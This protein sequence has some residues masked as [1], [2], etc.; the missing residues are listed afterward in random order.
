MALWPSFDACATVFLLSLSTLF[1]RSNLGSILLLLLQS[2]CS[3]VV[4]LAGGVQN[5]L[6]RG[7]HVCGNIVILV[8]VTIATRC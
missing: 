6:L 2:E 7:S 8:V 4:L 5:Y 3:L 1:V